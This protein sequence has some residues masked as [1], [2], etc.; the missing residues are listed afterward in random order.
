MVVGVEAATIVAAAVAMAA[1][2]AV[3]VAG[4]T[5]VV[6]GRRGQQSRLCQ[7]AGASGWTGRRKKGQT[8][9]RYRRRQLGK[10]RRGRMWLAMLAGVK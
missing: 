6:V 5:M 3:Q 2:A 8:A 1:T 10:R 9:R 4:V 7:V